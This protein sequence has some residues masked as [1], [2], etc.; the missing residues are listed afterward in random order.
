MNG[1][2]ISIPANWSY[3]FRALIIVTQFYTIVYN[4]K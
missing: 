1:L 4:I 3:C 2:P